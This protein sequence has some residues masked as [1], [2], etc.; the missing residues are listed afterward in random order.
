MKPLRFIPKDINIFLILN[1]L[2]KFEKHYIRRNFSTY[3]TFE[4]FTYSYKV[5]EFFVHGEVLNLLFKNNKNN[6]GVIDHDC[7]ILDSKIFDK[8]KIIKNNFLISIYNKMNKKANLT[9]P[10]TY[11]LFFNINQVK[12]IM[13]KYKINCLYYN[14]KINSIYF[15]KIPLQVQKKLGEIKLDYNNYPDGRIN[16]FDTL[17]LIFSMAIYEKL[18]FKFLSLK[19]NSIVH[20]KKTSYFYRIKKKDLILEYFI[21]KTLSAIKDYKIKKEYSKFILPYMK[22][23]CPEETLKHI[24]FNLRRSSR[25]KDI[26][27]L[28]SKMKY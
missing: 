22:Y 26:T 7:Y 15:Q 4:L 1:G 18:S 20:V 6:F 3:P 28:L 27:Y 10:K 5:G 19:K 17:E 24:S 23:R 14:Y 21:L 11:A 16:F 13:E 8:L 2:R 25:F 12:K 9:F